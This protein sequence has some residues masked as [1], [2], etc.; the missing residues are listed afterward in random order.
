VATFSRTQQSTRQGVKGV[1]IEGLDVVVQNF[2]READT[3]RPRAEKTVVD[4][5][6][7]MAQGMRDTVPVDEGDVLDS[8]TSDNKASREG[9]GVYADAGPDP[10]ANKA[11]FVA[12]FLVNGTVKMGQRWSIDAVADRVEPEFAKAIRDLSKL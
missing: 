6:E 9:F 10:R 4:Y 2:T 1:V 5:A 3:I 12:R 8:I 7:K 11:A